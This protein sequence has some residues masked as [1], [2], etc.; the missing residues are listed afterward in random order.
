MGKVT[1]ADSVAAAQARNPT[2]RREVL[3]IFFDALALYE[4]ASQNIRANGAVTG[5][6]KTGAPMVN[7]YVPIREAAGKAIARFHK[8]HPNYKTGEEKAAPR[9]PDWEEDLRALFAEVS[10]GE[11][12]PRGRRP[13]GVS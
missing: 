2:I 6:P 9:A 3:Q 10:L 8:E 4:E 11:P 5:N 7:P 13:K 12:A 1:A